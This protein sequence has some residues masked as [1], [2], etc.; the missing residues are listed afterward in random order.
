MR[1]LP[2]IRGAVLA[3][4]AFAAGG[5]GHAAAEPGLLLTYDIYYTGITIM[6]LE[7]R[8]NFAEK[9]QDEYAIA[10]DGRTVGLIHRLKPLAFTATS[11]GVSDGKGLQPARYATTTEK[12]KKHKSLTVAFQPHGTPSIRFTPMD[13]A[14]EPAPP[15][16]LKDTI[17][18]ASAVLTLIRTL[19]DTAS[20]AGKVQ[21]FDGKRRYD[22][23]FADLPLQMLQKTSY[24][25]YS[26]EAKRCHASMMPLHGFKPGKR[27]LWE[28]T[29]IWFGQVLDG[30]PALPVRIDTQIK[31]GA[32]K[33]HLVSARWLDQRASQ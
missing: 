14:E 33:L 21:V 3:L 27:V 10:L 8:L 22:V 28:D 31:I 18:P 7:A 11:E 12:R 1:R 32:V 29:T 23:K 5:A 2:P 16:L 15:E 19:S 4:L 13:D 30:A 24:S 6:R 26:G 25:I 17:D 20:C 9:A